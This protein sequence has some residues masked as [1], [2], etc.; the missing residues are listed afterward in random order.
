M[1]AC[2]LYNLMNVRDIDNIIGRPVLSVESANKLGHV[3]DLIVDP[4]QG[5]LAGLSIRRLD[6]SYALVDNHEIHSIGPDAVMVD[7]EESLASPEQS[8][9]KALP[10]AKNELIGV[11][12]ITESGQ[13][14]GKIANLFMHPAETPVHSAETPVFIYE[15]RSSVLDKLLRHA[16]FFPASLGCAFSA[17]RT[18]LV[19]SNDT[20]IAEHS[21]ET[22]V[23]RSFGPSE[24]AS[25]EPGAPEVTV[26]SHS[27]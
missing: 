4:L 6:Q 23:E 11:K 8:S 1:C 24:I 3:H 10:R 14:L 2:H 5:Q 20:Q 16:F 17:D 18:S 22:A 25:Y 9:I 19:V 27:Q 21:L 26:R 15:V 7:D 12:V 13:L